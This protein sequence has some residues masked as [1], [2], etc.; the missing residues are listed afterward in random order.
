MASLDSSIRA[1]RATVAKSMPGS[2]VLA[3]ALA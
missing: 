2:A 3:V 1:Q